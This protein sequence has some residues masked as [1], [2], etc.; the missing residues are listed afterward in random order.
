E[1]TAWIDSVK[2]IVATQKDDSNKVNTIINLSFAYEG[3]SSD[4]GLQ[5]A[6][7]ALRLAE[8]LHFEKG[9]FWAEINVAGALMILGNYP[10]NLDYCLR[11]LAL[12]KKRGIA[13][14]ISF[15]NG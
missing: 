1:Q 11:A 3:S 12:A 14:E 5:Y 10:L 9:I 4:T 6:Q 2:R 13:R 15:A 7:Q 8:N